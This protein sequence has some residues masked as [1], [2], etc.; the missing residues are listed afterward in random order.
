MKNAIKCMLV[1]SLALL[2]CVFLAACDIVS[3]GP[4]GEKGDVGPQGPQG[5]Q[6]I[7]G[8][9]GPQGVQGYRS[10]LPHSLAALRAGNGTWPGYPA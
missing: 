2:A 10:P 5:L 7:Q 6:G 3:Q 8:V 1:I 9:Q 4:Q